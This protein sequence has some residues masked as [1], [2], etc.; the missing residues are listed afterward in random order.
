MFY[1]ETQVKA[2]TEK[3]ETIRPDTG[4]VFYDVNQM[5]PE[6]S[7]LE[8]RQGES[9]TEEND[10]FQTDGE[11]A[12]P[13][14]TQDEPEWEETQGEPDFTIETETSPKTVSAMFQE[15]QPDEVERV[16]PE[17]EPE[18]TEEEEKKEYEPFVPERTPILKNLWQRLFRRRER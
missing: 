7:G 6:F 1:D 14:G 2:E 3:Y 4:T 17:S 9:E 15:A 8:E 12:G 13:E 18:D 10:E 11:L 5:T 16:L